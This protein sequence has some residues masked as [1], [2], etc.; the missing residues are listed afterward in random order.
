MGSEFPNTLPQPSVSRT[1]SSSSEE[2][3][4]GL[5]RGCW[6]HPTTRGFY[7]EFKSSSLVAVPRRGALLS[8]L[9]IRGW[10]QAVKF[11]TS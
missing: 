9:P 7:S 6:L 5:A 8:L 10:Q 4:W 1:L 11:L 2:G 3:G